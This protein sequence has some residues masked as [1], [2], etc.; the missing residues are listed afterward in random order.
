MKMLV[1][2][3]QLLGSDPMA[4]IVVALLAAFAVQSAVAFRMC[5][6]VNNTATYSDEEVNEARAH[7]FR[8]GPRLALMMIA[9]G[10]LMLAGLFMIAHG[11][12]PTLALGLLVTGIVV[13]QTE[14]A[15]LQLREQKFALIAAQG[16]MVPAM[17]GARARLRA[18]HRTLVVT[19]VVMLLAVIAGLLAF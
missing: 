2:E 15:R 7:Q 16:Q 4:W 1:E 5:P 3:L 9:G 17:Q 14:P 18:S 11:I 6:Y 12:K 8:A 13:T 10:A 19:N